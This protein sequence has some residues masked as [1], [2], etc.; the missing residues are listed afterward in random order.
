MRNKLS[1]GRFDF[2]QNGMRNF[3]YKT[4]CPEMLTRRRLVRN[5]HSLQIDLECSAIV[6]STPAELTLAGN[7]WFVLN[8][9]Q[10]RVQTL[11]TRDFKGLQ[12]T[13][14]EYAEER[15]LY[16]DLISKNNNVD[17]LKSASRIL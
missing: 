7:G 6:A 13:A 17:I 12:G 1:D 8:S 4:V 11:T 5:E 15:R 16:K 2:N 14:N 3:A 10:S 9:F